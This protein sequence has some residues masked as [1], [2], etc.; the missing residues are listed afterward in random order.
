MDTRFLEV[1]NRKI[2]YD[3]A[4]QGKLVICAPSMGDMR[5]EYRFLAPRLATAGYRVVTLDVRGHGESSPRW[6]DYSVAAIG[7][8]LLAL[9]RSLGAGPATL[10]GTSMAAGAAVWAAAEAPEQVNGLILID[11]FVRGG[12]DLKSRLLYAALFARPWGPALWRRYYASLYPTRKPDDFALYLAA[13]QA[14]LAE[15]GRLEA[16]RQMLFASKAASEVR[17]PKVKAPALV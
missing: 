5:G 16:L 9:V 6:P 15:P 4:G 2:A 1:T 12:G 7:S 10:I 11:P 13:L 14:N 17:L 3:V 8:D